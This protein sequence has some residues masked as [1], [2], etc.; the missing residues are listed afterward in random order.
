MSAC[1]EL[2]SEMLREEKS[3]VA[4]Q[5][6]SKWASENSET[7]VIKTLTHKHIHTHFTYTHTDANTFFFFNVI[8]DFCL[9][10]FYFVLL[11]ETFH[12]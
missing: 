10:Q 5:L 12:W 2:T 1:I 3:A 4:V 7:R 9:S 6:V 11:R 8:F